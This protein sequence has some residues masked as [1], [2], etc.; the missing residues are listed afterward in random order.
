H[1]YWGIHITICVNYNQHILTAIHVLCLFVTL[2]DPKKKN[3]HKKPMAL[4]FWLVPVISLLANCSTYLI[5]LGVDFSIEIFISA[6]IGVFFIVLGNYMPKLQ[7]NYTIGIKLPWTLNSEENWNRTHRLGG[8]LYI[9]MGIAMILMSFIDSLLGSEAAAWI[10]LSV[11][12]IGA[13][14]PAAYSFYLYKKGI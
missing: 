7:Q 8:K 13:I 14:I 5:A 3:I 12:T 6:L 2:N 4:I 9:V 1:I 10:I 11:I